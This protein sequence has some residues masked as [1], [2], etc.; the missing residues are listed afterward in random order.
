MEGSFDTRGFIDQQIV[1]TQ[2]GTRFTK[3]YT[4]PFTG[5]IDAHISIITSGE[6]GF[7]ENVSPYRASFVAQKIELAIKYDRL[8]LYFGTYLIFIFTIS[9]LR[10]PLFLLESYPLRLVI[11]LILM[12]IQRKKFPFLKMKMELKL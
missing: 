12:K 4:L 5:L 10:L 3:T 11:S 7:G 9:A 6:R 1:D 8:I 2:S